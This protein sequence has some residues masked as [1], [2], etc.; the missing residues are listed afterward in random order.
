MNMSNKDLL[1]LLRKIPAQNASSKTHCPSSKELVAS[2]APSASNRLKTKI[3]DHISGCPKCRGA[4]DLLITIMEYD[5]QTKQESSTE[6][7]SSRFLKSPL[8]YRPR[9]LFT[10]RV[11]SLI[12]GCLMIAVSILVITQHNY[13]SYQFREENMDIILE[14][15][16]VS[17][18]ITDKLIFRWNPYASARYYILELFDDALLPVW[19]SGKT[20][21]PQIQFSEEAR[22]ILQPGKAYFWMVTAY[23]GADD[24]KESNLARFVMTED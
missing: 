16:T 7:H 18:N 19:T 22:S 13:V 14:Y 9:Q 11:S 17:H 3:V 4:F 20:E 12:A 8:H 10:A 1:D 21:V 6:D 23:S 15:P 2:F 24:I 5:K